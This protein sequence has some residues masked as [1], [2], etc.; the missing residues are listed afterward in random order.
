MWPI[1]GVLSSVKRESVILQ[2]TSGSPIVRTS[3]GNDDIPPIAVRQAY[4]QLTIGTGVGGAQIGYMQFDGYDEGE[5]ISLGNVHQAW[6]PAN[7]EE[8][9]YYRWQDTGNYNAP[10]AS[11]HAEW[12][13]GNF[14]Q[15]DNGNVSP[16]W[17]IGHDGPITRFC[18]IQIDIATDL[19]GTN[20]VTTGYYRIG[21]S[22]SP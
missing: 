15:I 4:L 7:F 20:I 21:A 17:R 19:A 13:S 11:L 2:G 18:E 5:A 8:T 16:W 6:F 14:T 10:D 9:Y 12:T 1:G 3:L 22:Q